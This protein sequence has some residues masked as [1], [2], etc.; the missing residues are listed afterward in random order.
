VVTT[1]I[2]H[3]YHDHSRVICKHIKLRGHNLEK[4]KSK[5]KSTKESSECNSI[6]KTSQSA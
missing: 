3:K 4:K 1:I 5:W 2:G 6:A